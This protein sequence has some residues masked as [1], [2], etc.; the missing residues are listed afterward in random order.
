VQSD[1]INNHERRIG[2]IALGITETLGTR[3]KD[4]TDHSINSKPVSR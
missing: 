1:G 4:L 2:D 3:T